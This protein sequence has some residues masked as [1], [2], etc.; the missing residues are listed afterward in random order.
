MSFLFYAQ[1]NSYLS[2][3][4]EVLFKSGA[5]KGWKAYSAGSD[6]SGQVHPLTI[7]TLENLGLSIDG[8]WS[9]TIDDCEQYQTDVVITVCDSAAHEACPLYLGGTIKAHLPR[10]DLIVVINQISQI[11]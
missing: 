1:G 3:L 8:L 6:P 11:K 9:K 7:E 4:P 2:I 5:P 10:P